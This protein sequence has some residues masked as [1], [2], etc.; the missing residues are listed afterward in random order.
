MV[1]RVD[2]LATHV[3]SALLGFQ[4]LEK[5]PLFLS[6]ARLV[7]LKVL[8]YVSKSCCVSQGPAVCLKVLL[9]YRTISVNGRL[10]N[11]STPA[12]SSL[13]VNRRRTRAT[14]PRRR[15]V[16]LALDGHGERG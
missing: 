16:A 6:F 8:L 1:A 9:S 5:L 13:G 2:G 11:R 3:E 15:P 12:S 14:L 7:C 4:S 10:T